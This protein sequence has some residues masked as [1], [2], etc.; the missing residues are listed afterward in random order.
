MEFNCP[1]RCIYMSLVKEEV[2][3]YANRVFGTT[4]CPVYQEILILGV[5]VLSFPLTLSP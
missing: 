2:V 3:S 1:Q 5:C 4:K